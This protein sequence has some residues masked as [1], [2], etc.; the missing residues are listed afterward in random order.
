MTKVNTHTTPSTMAAVPAISFALIERRKG[1]SHG[2]CII[3]SPGEDLA[4][5]PTR[6]QAQELSCCSDQPLKFRQCET[7]GAFPNLIHGGRGHRLLGLEKRLYRRL[8][9]GI[10]FAKRPADFLDGAHREH[11]HNIL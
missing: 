9:V 1:A 5:C 6:C 4:T 2:F 7:K 11:D 8:Q 3:V 10:L